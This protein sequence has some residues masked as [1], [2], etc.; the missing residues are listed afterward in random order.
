MTIEERDIVERIPKLTINLLEDLF[1]G[2]CEI[3][4]G[5]VPETCHDRHC[6]LAKIRLDLEYFYGEKFTERSPALKS[7]IINLAV[8]TNLA[9]RYPDAHVGED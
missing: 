8:P 7:E 4:R 9:T 1:N 6:M 2:Y 3:C 5:Q